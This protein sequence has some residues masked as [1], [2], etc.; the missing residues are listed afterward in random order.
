MNK[1]RLLI[2]II[3]IL[4]AVNVAAII[5]G[6]VFTSERKDD[7]PVRTNIPYN[8]RAD[9]FR[10]QLG[11]NDSQKEKFIVFNREFNQRARAIT[12]KMNSLR[13]HM[14]EEMAAPHP[15]RTRID[16]ICVDIGMLHTELKR[17]TVDYY[18]KMKSV[19]TPE[20]QLELN[21]FFERIINADNGEGMLPGRGRQGRGPGMGR[22][23]QNQRRSMFN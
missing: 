21:R 8:R 1:T 13:F 23:R 7:L 9:V 2:W 5:S 15:D 3:I 17:A 22:V 4:V 11:L 12:G 20:Q 10:G 14:V 19:C 16:S 6:I 18:L